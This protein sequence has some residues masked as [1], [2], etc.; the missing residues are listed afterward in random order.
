MSN[1]TELIE[2][3][4]SVDPDLARDL[5][6]EVRDLNSQRKFGLVFERH[7]PESVNLPGRKVRRGSKVRMLPPRGETTKVDRRVW[8]VKTLDDDTATLRFIGTDKQ[9]EETERP[10]EDLVAVAE[11]NDTIYPG[12][13]P[14]GEVNGGDV[15]DPA[16]VVINAENYHALEMLTY[17]HKNSL[18]CI[19]IDPP[20][21]TGKDEWIYSDRYIEP[22]DDYRHSKWLAFMERRLRIARDLLRPTGVIIVAIGNEQ[23]HRL[24]M[25]IDQIF[26][27]TNFLSNVTWN[28]GR[29]NDSRFVSNGEDYMLVY[30]KDK[31]AWIKEGV[32]VKDSPDVS[33][34]ETA[35]DIVERGARWRAPKEGYE[36]VLE[37]G[38]EVWREARLTAVE[39]QFGSDSAEFSRLASAGDNTA[40]DAVYT[41]IN[42][43]LPADD[44]KQLFRRAELDGEQRMR[45]FYRQFPSDDPVRKTFGRYNYFLPDGTLCR[46]DNIT[47]PGGGGP[48]YDV[49]HPVTGKAVPVP[50]RGWRFSTSER[51]QEEVEAGRVIFRKDHTKP[52]SLKQPLEQTSGTVLLSAFDRQRTHGSR[53]LHWN[54]K[55]EVRGVFAENRFPNPK[56]VTVLAQWIEVCSPRDGVVLDFFGGSGSTLEAVALVN[57]RSSSQRRAIVVT[58]NEVGKKQAAAMTKDGLRKGDVEWESQ[59]VYEYV[60]KPRTRTIITGRREDGS[61]FS[62]GMRANAKF[63]TLTY[64]DP[65]AIQLARGF[66]RIAPLLWLRAGQQGPVIDDLTDRGYGVSAYYGVIESLDYLDDFIAEVEDKRPDLIYIITDDRRQFQH[67]AGLLPS[68]IDTVR[69]YESYLTNF[70][71]NTGRYA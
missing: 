20:Y 24:R 22:T 44:Q 15:D 71:V 49:L 52:V 16:H 37:K 50:D 32:K 6:N 8:T 23:Q 70:Q 26:G 11:F 9:V 56:D 17:T 1:F 54:N 33:S 2:R 36:A 30:A 65:L 18:D 21:N 64:E 5:E 19:Y 29:K 46:D 59:G 67:V 28:G 13:V 40:F 10:V 41:S 66:S 43:V 25:L 35:D 62:D 57:Q 63:F 53:H 39:Q 27:E 60:T 34:L 42:Q 68:G 48:A 3:A 7:L 55:G 69:L 12:L 58:N 38:A 14:D 4:R 51:M 61:D 47:W 31:T 45:A